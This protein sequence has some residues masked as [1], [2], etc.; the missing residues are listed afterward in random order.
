MISNQLCL[1]CMYKSCYT[2]RNRTNG[3]VLPMPGKEFRQEL[4]GYDHM[5]IKQF[6]LDLLESQKDN[7]SAI[8]ILLTRLVMSGPVSDQELQELVDLYGP[9]DPG[10]LGLHMSAGRWTQNVIDSVLDSPELRKK[11]ESVTGELYPLFEQLDITVDEFKEILSH[12]LVMIS[13]N[14]LRL[15]GVELN[16]KDAG[17]LGGLFDEP[18]FYQEL[19][20][21]IEFMSELIHA[22]E[23]ENPELLDLSELNMYTSDLAILFLLKKIRP[24]SYRQIFTETPRTFWKELEPDSEQREEAFG[25]AFTR[26]MAVL[27]G[28]ISGVSPQKIA[29]FMEDSLSE[30]EDDDDEMAK[31]S[32]TM[33]HIVLSH[34]DPDQQQRLL[35]GVSSHYEKGSMEEDFAYQQFF[36]TYALL[37]DANTGFE[38]NDENRLEWAGL[39]AAAAL[40]PDAPTEESRILRRV[41][42][43]YLGLRAAQGFAGVIG[44]VAMDDP[45]IGR[46]LSKAWCLRH[47]NS[48]KKPPRS[49]YYLEEENVLKLFDERFSQE[50]WDQLGQ[51]LCALFPEWKNPKKAMARL[52]QELSSLDPDHPLDHAYGSRQIA[53]E[54]LYCLCSPYWKELIPGSTMVLGMHDTSLDY[55]QEVIEVIPELLPDD[56]LEEFQRALELAAG[57]AEWLES[58]EPYDKPESGEDEDG[59]ED[60]EFDDFILPF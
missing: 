30:D 24:D 48:K 13:A 50:A 57:N 56:V 45:K 3:P 27:T 46:W 2:E 32:E 40:L 26:V 34:L 41:V 10:Q 52:N 1:F 11:I 4:C 28:K 36:Q 38:Y 9:Q 19:R 6:Y 5:E 22:D 31:W 12:I 14:I 16:L 55:L 8:P 21:V 37:D 29:Q 53:I 15:S 47:P 44:V 33:F 58:L 35:E 39:A 54:F 42:S 18:A 23:I 51:E 49:E 59:T 20:P 60:F 17:E 43:G 25:K 7:A